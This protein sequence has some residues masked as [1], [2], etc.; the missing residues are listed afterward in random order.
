MWGFSGMS[1]E[2]EG[3]T[4]ALSAASP[5]AY[6]GQFKAG[7]YAG[8]LYYMGGK[9]SGS[10]SHTGYNALEA[11][12]TEKASELAEGAYVFD[13]RAC[14]SDGVVAVIAGPMLDSSLPPMTTVRLFEANQTHGSIT[15]ALANPETSKAMTSVSPD[16]YAAFWRGLGCRIGRKVNGAIVWEE[17][18]S[19]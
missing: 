5:L 15:E 19:G 3:I 7:A 4:L 2:Y 14:G 10:T 11:L 9:V 1:Y 17:K 12:L 16:I 8:G 6:A 18:K 13:K